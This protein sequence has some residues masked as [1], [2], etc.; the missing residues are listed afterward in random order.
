M[1]VW[2]THLIESF[3]EIAAISAL[4]LRKITRTL[5][6]IHTLIRTATCQPS[7]NTVVWMK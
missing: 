6:E 2:L 3:S 1:I 4:I 7:G 5:L